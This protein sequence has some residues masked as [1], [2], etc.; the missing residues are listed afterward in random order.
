MNVLI[1]RQTNEQIIKK[2]VAHVPQLAHF[3]FSHT[4]GRYCHDNE[5]KAVE[6]VHIRIEGGAK[7]FRL[8]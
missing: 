1:H 2:I 6:P 5:V 4:Y 7:A 8:E 3:V